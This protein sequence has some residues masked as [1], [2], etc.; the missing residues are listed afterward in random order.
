MTAALP[1]SKQARQWLSLWS[2]AQMVLHQSPVNQARQARGQP[3]VN[4]VWLWGGGNLP[5]PVDNT[6]TAVYA[7][8]PFAQGLAK[9]LNILCLPLESSA[10]IDLAETTIRHHVVLDT[11]LMQKNPDFIEQRDQ[12]AAW[13]EQLGALLSTQALA[14]G[15]LNGLT[16]C[17]EVLLPP[18]AKSSSVF[19]RLA[20]LFKR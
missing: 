3:T 9:A 19:V 16:G 11:S 4:S 5:T 12:G 10:A 8:D 2:E 20:N 13:L 17:C 18:G 1:R 7:D 14:E 6:H 15:E